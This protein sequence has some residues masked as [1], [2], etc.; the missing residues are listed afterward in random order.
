MTFTTSLSVP[1]KGFARTTRV[2]QELSFFAMVLRNSS[3]RLNAYACS[4]A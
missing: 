3:S 1:A 4:R 2:E